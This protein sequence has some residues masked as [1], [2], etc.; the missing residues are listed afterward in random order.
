VR[1]RHEAVDDAPGLAGTLAN[2]AVVE[3]NAGQVERAAALYTE[4]ADRWE[5]QRYARW[6]AWARFAQHETL[7]ALG[8]DRGAT[9]ALAAA[10][11]AFARIGDRRGVWHA[12]RA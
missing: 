1:A 2:W 7:A 4:A 3:E 11:T 8:D 9:V 5:R 12:G 10:A 6:M